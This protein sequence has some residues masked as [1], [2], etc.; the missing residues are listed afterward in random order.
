MVMEFNLRINNKTQYCNNEWN[1]KFL[2]K[3]LCLFDCSNVEL[4][5]F[6]MQALKNIE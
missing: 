1:T 6:I 5:K 4:H 2:G 3:F